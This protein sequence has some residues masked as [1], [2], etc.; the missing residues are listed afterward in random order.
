MKKMFMAAALLAALSLPG[1]AQN[2]KPDDSKAKRKVKHAS[3]NVKQGYKHTR[4]DVKQGYKNTRH[5][6]KAGVDATKDSKESR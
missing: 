3:H 1:Y 2:D 4:H 6:V 5:D